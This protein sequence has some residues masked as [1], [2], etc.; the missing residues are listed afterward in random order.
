VRAWLLD[1]QREA[2]ERGGLVAD[3]R[4]MGTVVFPDAEVKVFLTATLDER[5]RRRLRD[6]GVPEPR[7]GEI[8]AESERIGR[9]DA[10]D[11]ER[12][13]APLRPAP[14]ARV[15]DTTAMDFEAQVDAIVELVR[16]RLGSAE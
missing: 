13:L 16:G 12:E 4:D 8:G 3:G 11:S 15:L 1:R 9:R 7:P 5:A 2:G 14:D 6:H 10:S